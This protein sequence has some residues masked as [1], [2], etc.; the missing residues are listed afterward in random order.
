MIQLT[1]DEPLLLA[2]VEEDGRMY[3]TVDDPDGWAYD[4]EGC[5]R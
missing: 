4:V 1:F 2:T 5:L 3:G